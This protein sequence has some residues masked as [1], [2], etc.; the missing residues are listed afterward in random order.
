MREFQEVANFCR[1]T[2]MG[3]QGPLL[4]WC[5]KR[6]DGLICKK[7]DRVL[8]N[9]D[10]LHG[11]KAYSVFEAGGCSDHLRCRIHF[12][13]EEERK[14]NPFKFTNAIAKMPEFLPLI[15]VFWKDHE[16]LF[17]ST[18]A[19]FRLTKRLKLLK[20]PLRSL[21]KL[22]LGDL[23]K[24]TKEAYGY[25]CERQKITLEHPDTVNIK[26]E[27]KAYKIWQRLADLE[28]D[29]LK[30]KAKLFWLD[31]GDGNN[32]VFHNAAKIREVRNS[33][34]EIKCSDGRI[35]TTKE[36]IKVEAVSFF[37]AFMSA[38][39]QEFEG[40]TVERLRELVGVPMQWYR[41]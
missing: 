19:M 26:E 3:F 15:E 31:V 13:D 34:H 12:E 41:L 9:E 35:V 33:I 11:K 22:K 14:R 1:F 38:Q 24:R 10:W 40:S 7:L 18:T 28:E 2:D 36:E 5:N 39:P 16:V 6:E 32:R 37:E 17:H 23:S 20:Q 8:I 29:Y 27:G 21:S 4:T 30:Q 25:L